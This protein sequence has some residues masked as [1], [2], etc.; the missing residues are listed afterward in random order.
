[1]HFKVILTVS[2]LTLCDGDIN[3]FASDQ[4]D[5]SLPQR[6]MVKVCTMTTGVASVDINQWD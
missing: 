6:L 1:M 2:A 5:Q 4:V 3:S